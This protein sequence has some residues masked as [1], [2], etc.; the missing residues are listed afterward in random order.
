MQISFERSRD[1]CGYGVGWR[2][3]N[4]EKRCNNQN[5]DEVVRGIK[6]VSHHRGEVE[7]SYYEVSQL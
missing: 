5:Q 3:T 7:G 2:E 1:G 4:G 6:K